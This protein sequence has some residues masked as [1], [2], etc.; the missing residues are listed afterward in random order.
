[1]HEQMGSHRDSLRWM[2]RRHAWSKRALAALAT[3]VAI[4]AATPL[5]AG[6]NQW[7]GNGPYGG[8]V[9]V[10]AVDPQTPATLYAAGFS[11]VFKSSNGGANWA[12][13]SDGI[14]DPSVDALVVDP[15]T[16]TTLYAGSTQGGSVVKSTNAGATWAP[17]A[18]APTLVIALAINPQAPGT[19]YASQQQKRYFEERQWRD[20]LD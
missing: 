18:G 15:V 2:N 10:L 7:T 4:G 14:A 12:R 19:V 6:S 16:P 20:I 1:M 13:A 17:L 11:G 3:L 9:T 8:Q 5:Q